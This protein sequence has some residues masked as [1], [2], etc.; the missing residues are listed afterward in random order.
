MRKVR[1][2]QFILEKCR[3]KNAPPISGQACMCSVALTN[4]QTEILLNC[5]KKEFKRLVI[6]QNDD[7]S[8]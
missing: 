1:K 8:K 7:Q 4:E 6:L 2:M 5:S 3:L